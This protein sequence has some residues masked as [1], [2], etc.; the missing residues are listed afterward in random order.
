V[1]DD[2]P[3]IG[4]APDVPG[5]VWLAGLSGYGVQSSPATGR[6]AA[7]AATGTPN[8]LDIEPAEVAP[9]RCL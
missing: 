1:A 5:F 4:S 6:L 9:D 3:V 8:G 7:A 2:T